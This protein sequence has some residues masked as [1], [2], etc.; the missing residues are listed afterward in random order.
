M[1]CCRVQS[2]ANTALAGLINAYLC[3]DSL[4]EHDAMLQLNADSQDIC[5]TGVPCRACRREG[6]RLQDGGHVHLSL[7][8]S[9]RLG[10][11]LKMTDRSSV[12]GFAECPRASPNRLSALALAL[13]DTG[14]VQ[15]LEQAGADR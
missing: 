9:E 7:S 13:V 12:P 1:P 11:Y 15:R 2:T 8:L 3:T 14:A 5:I 4:T 10:P 6:G